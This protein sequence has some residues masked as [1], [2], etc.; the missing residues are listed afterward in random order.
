MNNTYPHDGSQRPLHTPEPWRQGYYITGREDRN[1]SEATLKHAEE[2][3]RLLV[4]SGFT[5]E[6]KGRSR[7]FVARC[8]CPE[9]AKR[10]ADC[11]N[12]C[13]GMDDPAAEIDKL[14]LQV[15]SLDVDNDRL[16][17]MQTQNLAEIADLIADHKTLGKV[18]MDIA[19][20]NRKLRADSL[21]LRANQQVLVDALVSL[22]DWEEEIR[23]LSIGKLNHCLSEA[24]EALNKVKESENV[25]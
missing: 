10:I 6:D 5:E 12:A 19:I 18:S 8:D 16:R 11:I 1:K 14:K 3:E 9:D 2:T 22:M 7:I 17:E 25:L 13:A 23:V 24:R 20:E 4:F 15:E 21:K